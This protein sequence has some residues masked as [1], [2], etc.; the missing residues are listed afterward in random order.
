MN[1]QIKMKSYF[2]NNVFFERN[3]KFRPKSDSPIKML[4]DFKRTV[5]KIDGSQAVV[6]LEVSIKEKDEP[7][8][9]TLSAAVSGVFEMPEWDQSQI[10]RKVLADLASNI[11]YPYLRSLVSTVTANA[12]VPLYNL[13]IMN[14]VSVFDN[15]PASNP[16]VTLQ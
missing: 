2:V 9:F 3:D 10:L 5:Y 15:Q 4:P 11:L 14:I 6:K 1:S 16:D 7:I 8:P 13:P 12:A